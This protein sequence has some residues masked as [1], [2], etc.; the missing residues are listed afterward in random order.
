M[1]DPENIST[2]M[3]HKELFFQ[4]AEFW[5]GAAF[6]L[7]V[8]LLYTPVM[9][10]IRQMIEKRITRIRDELQE[11]ENLKLEAQQLYADYER[12]FL[13]TENE[14]AEIISNQERIIAETKERKLHELNSLLKQKEIEADAKI[15]QAFEKTNAEINA[16]ISLRMTNILEKTLK[17]CLTSKEQVKLVDQSIQHLIN[18]D[19]R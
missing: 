9:H 11:A 19:L 6:V 10:A 5:V 18:M 16:L 14:V 1:P 3:E 2:V 7:V 12:K 8:A 4:S 13:N 17:K 15:E